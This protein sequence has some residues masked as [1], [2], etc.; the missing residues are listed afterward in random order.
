MLLGAGSQTHSGLM[1]VKIGFAGRRALAKL[2]KRISRATLLLETTFKPNGGKSV[3][4]RSTMKIV[5]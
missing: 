3:T 1:E 2:A 5:R 4:H